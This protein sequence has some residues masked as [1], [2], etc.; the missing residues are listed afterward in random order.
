MVIYTCLYMMI[1][2]IAALLFAIFVYFLKQ[3]KNEWIDTVAKTKDSN[4]VS[5]HIWSH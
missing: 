4:M 1:L 2:I 5:Q 3:K